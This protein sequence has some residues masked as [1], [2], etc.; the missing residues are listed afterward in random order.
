[1]QQGS[2]KIDLNDHFAF[3]QLE[4]NL[5]E[6]LK[7][8]YEAEKTINDD[9]LESL[10]FIYKNPLLEALNQIDISEKKILQDSTVVNQ[11]TLNIHPESSKNLL[12]LVTAIKCTVIPDQV[13]YQVKGSFDY[14]LFETLNF[15]ACPGFKY[16]VLN[17]SESLYCKHIVLVKLVKAM[18]KLK[19]KYVKESE[20]VESIKQ[21]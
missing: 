18:N 13:V 6:Q 11:N 8:S 14:Y 7:T 16:G 12:D 21:I 17:S 2:I 5:L 4:S 1:M 15:C 10:Y 9:L 19:V 3:K 20:F